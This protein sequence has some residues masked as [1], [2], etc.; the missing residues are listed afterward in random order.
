MMATEHTAFLYPFLD[1]QE[2]NGD[3]RDSSPRA[4]ADRDDRARRDGG[5][6]RSGQRDDGQDTGGRDARG[7]KEGRGDTGGRGDTLGA[8]LVELADSARA[9]ARESVRL[10]RATLRECAGSIAAT[11]A[12]M[13]HRF[14]RG[15][16][17]YTFG[18][19]GSATDAATLAELF[20]RPPHGRPL[21]AWSL[22][23]DQAVVTA[24]GNDVGFERVFARQ[25]I[26]H[27]GPNDIAV[28]LSTSGDSSN[29]LAG[30]A[31]AGRRGALTVG[32]AGYDG[33]RFAADGVVDRC[34][35]VHSQS[36]HRI[37][38][39]HA[40]LGHHLWAATQRRMA[41]HPAAPPMSPMAGE[42][43]R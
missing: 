38:E 19:G 11:A 22:A 10:Q 41:D 13:A 2:D 34:F 6:R 8:L 7:R 20:S 26:A 36:V 16:R 5:H 14:A 32:F 31:E 39:S 28:A 15:G 24:L 17:M 3:D 40:L 30:L 42:N 4:G 25:L 21:P 9:K 1:P 35:V 29:L 18:N 27:A 23:A 12:E 43:A 37:Q 33:G